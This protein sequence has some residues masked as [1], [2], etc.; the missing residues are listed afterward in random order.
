MCFSCYPRSHGPIGIVGE[1]SG[2]VDSLCTAT[3]AR[4]IRFPGTSPSHPED[5]ADL[6]DPVLLRRIGD[7]DAAAFA[8]LH[9]RYAR[10]VRRIARRVVGDDRIAEE[11]C[12]EAFLRL[13]VHCRVYR[14]ER[15]AV[16]SWLYRIARNLAVDEYR[17][18]RSAR[19]AADRLA[20]RVAA[21]TAYDPGPE[22]VVLERAL[23]ARLASALQRLP[24]GEAQVVALAYLDELTQRE[25]AARLDLSLGRVKHRVVYG[26]RSLRADPALATLAADS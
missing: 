11:I 21:T 23:H 8:I 7:G 19:A 17:R 13:W 18:Q 4:R 15:G 9:A 5:L 16:G 14:E 1:G 3:G 26:L 10:P 25:I 12:Q 6:P 20:D 2:A 24:E 22:Q